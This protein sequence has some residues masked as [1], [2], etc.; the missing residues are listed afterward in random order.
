[1]VTA[2]SSLP[3]CRERGSATPRLQYIQQTF[4][5][6]HPPSGAMPNGKP[7]GKQSRQ[8]LFAEAITQPK[9]MA[10]L[11]APTG[12]LALPTEPR[13]V[14][15]MDRIVQEI[16]V[17]ERRLEAMDLK[18]SDLSMA[19]TSIWADITAFRETVTDL[20]HHLTA[21]E[22]RVATLPDRDA[23]LRL[24]RM[25]VTDLEDRSRRDNV[26][27]FGISE[28]KGGSDISTFLKILIPELTG[29]DFSPPLEFQRVHR[30]GPMHKGASR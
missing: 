1:M 8:L 26:S 25:K 2:P 10:A 18:I 4:Q 23:D 7:S 19:S 14:E 15:A 29:L 3:F 6:C 22:D 11:T 28:H 16:T 17:V 12:S 13:T 30:I 24:L 27:F 9:V 20:D 21:V 5:V